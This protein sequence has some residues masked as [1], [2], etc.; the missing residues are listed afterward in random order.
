MSVLR[1]R[2]L[3]SLR[4]AGH[5]VYGWSRSEQSRSRQGVPW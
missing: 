1:D 3:A 2:K 4:D 5:G